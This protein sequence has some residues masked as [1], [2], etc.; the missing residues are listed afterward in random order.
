MGQDIDGGAGLN[1]WFGTSIS[2]SALGTRVAIGGHEAT[3]P[4]NGLQAG[5]ARVYDYDGSAWVLMG[6]A[7]YGSAAGD[8]LGA[9]ASVALS[10][11]GGR[12]AVGAPHDPFFLAAGYARVFEWDG[13]DWAQMGADVVGELSDDDHSGWS[14]SLSASG[15]RLAVGAHFSNATGAQ[16]GRAR[17][18]QWDGSAWLLMGQ[19]IEGE[20]VGDGFGARVSLSSTG[21]RIAISGFHND[22]GGASSGHVRVYEW[23]GNAWNQ[24]GLDI[25]GGSVGEWFGYSLSLSGAGTRVAI[26]APRNDAG[27]GDAGEVSVYEWNGTAWNPLGLAISGI[28]AGHQW[29]FSVSISSDGKRVAA[30]APRGTLVSGYTREFEWDGTAWVQLGVDIPGEALGDQ[31]GSAVSLSQNGA[32]L[33]IGAPGNAGFKLAGEFDGHARVYEMIEADSTVSAPTAGP[34]QLRLERI[35]P[36]PARRIDLTIELSLPTNDDARLELLDLQG[37]RVVM[38]AIHPGAAG[39][40]ASRLVSGKVVAPGL[41]WVRLTQGRSQATKQ[42]VVLE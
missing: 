37:R 21:N 23:N 8:A 30:G 25:D 6:Q 34:A 7:I 40:L 24:L 19:P 4:S 13:L 29:G 5:I 42:V 14:V 41:Y 3:N 10:A 39:R 18:Y 17:I 15:T 27:G 12:L 11:G 38:N 33:A 36:N 28:A 22:G 2:L 31:S 9:G 26:G 32:R 35:S 20:A 16:S 1:E